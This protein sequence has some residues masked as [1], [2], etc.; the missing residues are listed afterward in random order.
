MPTPQEWR[1]VVRNFEDRGMQALLQAPE[2]ARGLLCI[3]ASDLCKKLDF[4][5]MVCEPVSFIARDLLKREAD[6]VLRVPYRDPAKDE[7]AEVWVY[8]L[9]EHQSAP[10]IEMPVRLLN[11]ISGLWN[12][13]LR[14][15]DSRDGPVRERRYLPVV[16]IVLYTGETAWHIDAPVTSLMEVP[17]DLERFQP[18]FAVL[19]LDVKHTAPADLVACGHPFA[20]ILRVIQE[21]TSPLKELGAV[22]AEAV[23]NIDGLEAVDMTALQTALVFLY[24]LLHH[25]RERGEADALV[26]KMAGGYPSAAR[27][28]AI[29]M[30]KTY[31]QE[32]IE[33]G[34]ARGRVRSLRRSLLMLMGKKFGSVPEPI[35]QRV[36]SLEDTEALDVL[37]TRV[38]DAATLDDMGL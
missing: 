25:R 35:V 14:D 8:L 19:P 6:L 29:D 1:E 33:E 30:A 32:L 28:E 38:L 21:E 23:R 16:P 3:V 36:N 20:W 34:E 27:K 12:R 31:A 10:D 37:M 24:M 11:G 9:L 18:R 17:A 7:A 26:Q 22:L 5:R 13:Q 4:H 2:N 15:F